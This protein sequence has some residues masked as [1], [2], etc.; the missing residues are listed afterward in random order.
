MI[1]CLLLPMLIPFLTMLS[2]F[3]ES[4]TT[5]I[6]LAGLIVP[7]V[8]FAAWRGYRH[9]GKSIVVWLLLS[10]TLAVIVAMVAGEQ[11]SSESLEAGMTTIGSVL[12]IAGHWQNHKHR[13]RCTN[14]M[15]H[16]H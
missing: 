4:E 8:I 15:P 3:A 9:H 7:T 14:P 12:L 10:G 1:H 6:V 16:K 13:A 2:A 11:F 5:H